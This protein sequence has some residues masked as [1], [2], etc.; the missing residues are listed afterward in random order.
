MRFC[1]WLEILFRWVDLIT[2]NAITAR[3]TVAPCILQ[4]IPACQKGKPEILH[5]GSLAAR[6][7]PIAVAAI[8]RMMR[9]LGSRKYAE[10]SLV[11]LL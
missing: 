9:N 8:H 3:A 11:L 2:Y 6:I 4:L 1:W 5:M 7:R 10:S